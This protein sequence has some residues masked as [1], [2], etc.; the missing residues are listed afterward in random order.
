MFAIFLVF[1]L[2]ETDPVNGKKKLKA[3]ET[4]VA[5]SGKYCIFVALFFFGWQGWPPIRILTVVQML[6][7]DGD[8]EVGGGGVGGGGGGIHTYG[9][10]I[11]EETRREG[12]FPC[13][14]GFSPS[15]PVFVL[16]YARK[17]ASRLT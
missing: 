13:S 16:H 6:F 2:I 14:E 17:P 1:A 3:N 9:G 11:W 15:S 10:K 5:I 8:C 12:S 7:C 4:I